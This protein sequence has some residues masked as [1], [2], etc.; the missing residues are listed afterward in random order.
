MKFDRPLSRRLVKPTPGARPRPAPSALE[1]HYRSTSNWLVARLRRRFCET[2]ADDIAQEAY[3]RMSR[4]D[5]DEVRH[6]NTL[7]LKV[8]LN[9]GLSQTRHAASR[10]RVANLALECDA[11]EID[12]PCPLSRTRRNC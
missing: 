12:A 2:L 9:A 11:A 10:T 8:A 6:P 4:I 7:L 5:M 1:N 3:L